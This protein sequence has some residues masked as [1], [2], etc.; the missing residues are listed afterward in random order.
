MRRSLLLLALCATACGDDSAPAPA[1]APTALAPT[2]PKEAPLTGL[3]KAKSVVAA[4]ETAAALTELEA[5][6]AT[7]PLALPLYG[8]VA[9]ESG[10]PGDAL[11]RL[12]DEAAPA[13]HEAAY[14][15]LRAELA[16]AAGQPELVPGFAAKIAAA[17]PEVAAALI[18]QA[19]RAGV[20]APADQTTPEDPLVV[21]GTNPDPVA[22]ATALAA[23]SPTDWVAK[24]VRAPI[25]AAGGQAALA[26]ADLQNL[27]DAPPSP[28]AALRAGQA[29]AAILPDPNQS[30]TPLDA[31]AKAAIELGATPL[32]ARL[33]HEAA[34]RRLKSGRAKEAAEGA[35]ALRE[36]LVTAKDK[37]GAAELGATLALA[38][39]ERGDATTALT[40]TQEVAA[41]AAEGQRADLAA[42]AGRTRALAAF[43]LGQEAELSAAAAALSAPWSDAAEALRLVLVGQPNKALAH[44]GFSFTPLAADAALGEAFARQHLHRG[45]LRAAEYS[46]DQ[47]KITQAAKDWVS[48]ADALGAMTARLESRLEW[49]RLVRESGARP[50][51]LQAE[52]LSLGQ[53]L[54]EPG[55]PLRAE[56]QA[57]TLTSG[58]AQAFSETAAAAEAPAWAV[59]ADPNNTAP[60]ALAEHPIALVARARGKAAAG[61]FSG[62]YADWAKGYGSTPTHLR[63][64]LTPISVLTGGQGAGV[65]ADLALLHGK[66]GVE[67][68]LAGVLLLDWHHSV[69]M[70]NRAWAVGDDPS[71]GLEPAARAAY[72]QA[73]QTLRAETLAWLAG[74]GAEPIEAKK[75]VDAQEAKAKETPAFAR[76]LPAP[77]ADYAKLRDDMKGLAIFSM[78]LEPGGGELV[79]LTQDKGRVVRIA[80]TKSV[81]RTGEQLVAALRAGEASGG[82][83]VT[84]K[85]G[86]SL[87][88]QLIDPFLDD[89]I[90]VGRYLIVADGPLR[91]L[92]LAGLP[93]QQQGLRFLADVRTVTQA[94]TV[95]ELRR[96]APEAPERFVTDY[97]GLELGEAADASEGIKLAS[98]TEATGRQFPAE[99]RSTPAKAELKVDKLKEILPT[100]RFIHLAMPVIGDRGSIKL[101]EETLSLATVRGLNLKGVIAVIS[102]DADAAVQERWAQALHSAGVSAVLRSSWLI[103]PDKRAKV[104]FRFFESIIQDRKPGVALVDGRNALQGEDNA[105]F[106]PS[107]WSGFLLYDLP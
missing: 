15:R 53:S 44:P 61:D 102:S 14:H 83:K 48:A 50:A 72:L 49:E 47:A 92:S 85:L 81:L 33:G 21:A 28:E 78:R 100:A 103:P 45:R 84:P 66:T 38:A 2:A 8:L 52:L 80:D 43:A 90:G 46:G 24:V 107:W 23:L 96:P 18:L 76:A 35:T 10:T 86:D 68:G 25:L 29:L 57:R 16:L 87:R 3:A 106:D 59:L 67:A 31:A 77:L 91:E 36:A 39:L 30:A 37:V 6:F 93:E 69:G 82:A 65:R 105:H 51:E 42:E 98:E 74:S 19:R 99:R 55:A 34:L 95:A 27:L 63:G 62:A 40:L 64:P 101:G 4:R 75:A 97:L 12:T 26:Q 88:R 41:F 5:L 104:L 13:G 22:A 1:A 89:L 11:A 17:S 20:I 9:M 73:H 94:M 71:L 79:V 56:A 7:E 70:M 60:E 54:G 58:G 32:A